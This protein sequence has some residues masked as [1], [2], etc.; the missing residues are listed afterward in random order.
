MEQQLDLSHIDPLVLPL[1]L[2][3]LRRHLAR[4]EWRGCVK[5]KGKKKHPPPS[6]RGVSGEGCSGRGFQWCVWG[7]C[8]GGGCEWGGCEWGMGVSGVGW[9]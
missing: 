6:K 9:V 2:A 8:V 3:R 1:V 5:K 4:C 7:A